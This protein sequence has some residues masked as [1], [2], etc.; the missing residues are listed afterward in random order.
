MKVLNEDKPHPEST[1]TYSFI[2]LG[3]AIIGY[4]SYCLWLSSADCVYFFGKRG[5]VEDCSD[6]RNWAYGS[7]AVASLMGLGFL[8]LGIMNLKILKNRQ[9]KSDDLE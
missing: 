2:V 3:V 8:V 6:S 7:L 1:A 4:V 9:R 5:L